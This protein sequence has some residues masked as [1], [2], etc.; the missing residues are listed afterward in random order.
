MT[1]L[2][3]STKGQ[4]VIPKEIRDELGFVPGAKVDVER[5]GDALTLRLVKGRKSVPVDVL[6]GRF[7]HLYSG[8]PITEEQIDAAAA[9]GAAARWERS[10]T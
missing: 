4:I 2:T 6:F 3:V 8:P 9:A 10:K 7:K 1:T 5:N